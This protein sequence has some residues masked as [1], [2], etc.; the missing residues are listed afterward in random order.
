MTA[1]AVLTELGSAREANVGSLIRSGEKVIGSEHFSPVH[2]ISHTQRMAVVFGSDSHV[3]CSQ[4]HG[5]Q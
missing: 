3:P 2:P 5:L 4:S 1:M